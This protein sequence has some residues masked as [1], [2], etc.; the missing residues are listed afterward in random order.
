MHG[1]IAAGL[2]GN[3]RRRSA[4]GRG[5]IARDAAHLRHQSASIRQD[6]GPEPASPVPVDSLFFRRRAR[7]AER[8][9]RRSAER[10]RG[11]ARGNVTPG[12]RGTAK[13]RLCAFCAPLR[14]LCVERNTYLPALRWFHGRSRELAPGT[15][16]QGIGPVT[17]VVA[18]SARG[19]KYR[20]ASTGQSGEMVRLF[21]VSQSRVSR[22]G[23]CR[24]TS[25]P[26]GQRCIRPVQRTGPAYFRADRTAR[27]I[28]NLPFTRLPWMQVHG[29]VVG[30]RAECERSGAR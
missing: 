14:A 11:R 24:M 22:P 30:G 12:P 21:P 18:A 5:R 6:S 20:D 10:A 8:R 19:C 16:L 23:P 3:A 26:R 28:R 1:L 4:P 27:V 7:R 15:W 29:K 2:P 25:W 17:H 13:M 9:A